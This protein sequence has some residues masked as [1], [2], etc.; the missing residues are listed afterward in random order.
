M[1]GWVGGWMDGGVD[2]WMA[3]KAGL[4][5]AYSNQ[6]SMV[7]STEFYILRR[8]MKT[9]KWFQSETCKN[10][11]LQLFLGSSKKTGIAVIYYIGLFILVPIYPTDTYWYLYRQNK[12]VHS[13]YWTYQFCLYHFWYR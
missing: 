12:Y 1:D 9:S 13:K 8:T 2:G 11:Y 10:F 5:I 3:G 4:S 7:S 6:K